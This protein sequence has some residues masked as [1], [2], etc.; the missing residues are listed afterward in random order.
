MI[1]GRRIWRACMARQDSDSQTAT[2]AASEKLD[3]AHR[4]VIALHLALFQAVELIPTGGSSSGC[5]LETFNDL[6]I[7]FPAKH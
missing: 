2:V 4:T 5:K 1:V 6:T 7:K 3:C